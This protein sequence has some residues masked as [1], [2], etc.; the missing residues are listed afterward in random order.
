V[1]VCVCDAC[2]LKLV[3]IEPSGFLRTTNLIA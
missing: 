3:L 2:I 1:C